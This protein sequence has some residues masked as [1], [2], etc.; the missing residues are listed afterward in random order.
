MPVPS[1]SSIFFK[2][3]LIPCSWIARL[4]VSL[5]LLG[6]F[7]CYFKFGCMTCC[8]D[9]FFIVFA[10]LDEEFLWFMSSFSVDAGVN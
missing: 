8:W 4:M 1:L 9:I 7:S 5:L 2:V 10:V 6:V 3:R